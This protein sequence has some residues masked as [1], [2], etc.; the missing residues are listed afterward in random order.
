MVLPLIFLGGAAIASGVG[1]YKLWLSK[2]EYADA[3]AQFDGAY[4]AYL[5]VVRTLEAER[6][7]AKHDLENLGL[8][9]LNAMEVMGRAVAFLEKAKLKQRN[10]SVEFEL[11]IEQLSAFAGAAMSAH[12]AALGLQQSAMAG[13]ATAAG[14]YGLVG[15]LASAG[16]GTAIASLSGA[17]AQSATL[18]WL[19]GG[20]LAAG[21]GG[22]ALGTTVL[23]GLV[24]GPALAVAGFIVGAKVSEFS[25]EVE[26][27]ITLL[28]SDAGVKEQFIVKLV[29]LRQ[30]IGEVMST[31]DGLAHQL[32]LSVR[33][34]DPAVHK[35]AHSVLKIAV[36]LGELLEASVLTSDGSLA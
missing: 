29:A 26:R 30:R 31:T 24:V 8:V 6:E 23:G 18:A 10:L 34:A 20:A 28:T 2:Q 4:S 21:G 19:G 16:T 27:Q 36:R 22:V 5:E 12:E 25:N 17:A 13:A 1:A 11:P 35:D 15:L 14:A 32:D 33:S 7:S 3:R 9:R